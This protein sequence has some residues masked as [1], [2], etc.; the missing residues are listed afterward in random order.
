MG[1][2]EPESELLTQIEEG[3]APAQV[4][5]FAARGLVP[6]PASELARA[7]GTLLAGPDPTLRALAEE[8][9]RSLPVE[10]LKEAVLSPG[11]R[12]V[13]LDA[14]A[15]RTA[16]A[17]ILEPLIRHKEVPDETLAWLAD[18]VDPYLQDVLVT[19]QVR[20]LAS[21]VIV[22]RLFENPH[23]STDIRRR[24]DEFLEEFFLKKE[25]EE[26]ERAAA[27]A[28]SEVGEDTVPTL[29]AISPAAAAEAA[30]SDDVHRNLF[31]RLATLGV[32][33]KIRLAW[34]GTKEERLFLVRDTN[35]LVATAVL[36]SP[37]TREGDVEVIANMKSVSEDVLRYIAL[38]REW[39][40][41]YS[42]V[43]AL[44][45]NPRSPID[46]T[47][48]LVIRLSHADQKKLS[49]DR[50]VPEPI[51]KLARREVSRR[52]T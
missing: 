17:S 44:V 51:R 29:E 22:E 4:L 37:K 40:R 10:A 1:A 2:A 13:Q 48:P 50:N 46:A 43:A 6:L 21:P 24:A 32:A 30:E 25:R 14:I 39:M 18:R 9:F 3:T 8:S 28:G 12:P 23:L 5:E 19:N 15:R 38:R 16:D 41:K 31:A 36:K 33:Q 20:L 47:L 27:A 7:L 34:R 26:D 45:R 35:R 42:I 11:V 52:E 49:V